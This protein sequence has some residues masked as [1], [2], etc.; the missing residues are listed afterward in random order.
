MGWFNWNRA[1]LDANIEW[2]HNLIQDNHPRREQVHLW[3][4]KDKCT[5]ER[6]IFI[7]SFHNCIYS[8][9][10]PHG[11]NMMLKRGDKTG[12]TYK[13]IDYDNTLYGYRLVI[14]VTSGE[15]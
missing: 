6:T 8:H 10:D 12:D 15:M 5:C 1:E 9:N 4:V 11:G 13:L 3:Q 2:L 14:S 7:F